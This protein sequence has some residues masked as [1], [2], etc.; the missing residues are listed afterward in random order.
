MIQTQSFSSLSSTGRVKWFNQQDLDL[1]LAMTVF[2]NNN[3]GCTLH[4]WIL[5][6]SRNFRRLTNLSLNPLLP[7][8]LM[9]V[10]KGEVVIPTLEIAPSVLFLLT[11]TKLHQNLYPAWCLSNMRTGINTVAVS[12]FFFSFCDPIL[13]EIA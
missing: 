6:S 8:I 12:V 10:L 5:I 7:W 4:S 13:A 1:Q 11:Q 2:Q 9:N 3:S